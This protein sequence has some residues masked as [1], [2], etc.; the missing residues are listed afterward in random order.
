MAKNYI[1]EGCTLNWTN[2]TGS[3]VASGAPVVVGNRQLAIALVAIAAAAVGSVALEGVFELAKDT[4][5][6]TTDGHKL[7]WDAA[8][9]K[10]VNAPVINSYFIGYAV[11]SELAATATCKVQLEEFAEE[12]PRVLTLAATGAQTLTVGDF[13]GGDLILF[14][15]NTAAQTVNLPSV[16]TIPPGSK[17][18]V[19]KTSADAQAVTLDPASTEQINGGN[20]FATIDAA[21]DFAQFVSTGAAWNLVHSVIA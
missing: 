3:A 6:A 9:S 8:N 13:G 17:L 2:G 16:A 1:Q 11:G 14:A 7:W 20:T 5:Q 18:T 4:S 10:I 15:P 12:G 21:N 19:R